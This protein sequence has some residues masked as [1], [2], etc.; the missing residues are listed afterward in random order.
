VNIYVKLPEHGHISWLKHIAA[1]KN[2]H[3]QQAE[4]ETCVYET[5]AWKMRNMKFVVKV[6]AQAKHI[7]HNIN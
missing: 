1:V 5:A 7:H 6:K 4:S 2:K 3:V